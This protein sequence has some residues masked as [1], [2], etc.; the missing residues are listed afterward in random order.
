MGIGSFE[1][2]RVNRQMGLMWREQ[3]RR[4]GDP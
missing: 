2:W 1:K 3:E 4:G